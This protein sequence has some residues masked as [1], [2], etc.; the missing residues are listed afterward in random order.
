MRCTHPT[1]K[2]STK[3]ECR[4]RV[5]PQSREQVDIATTHRLPTTSFL[6]GTNAQSQKTREDSSEMNTLLVKG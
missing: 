6:V 3:P 2:L 5:Q 4:L 1:T